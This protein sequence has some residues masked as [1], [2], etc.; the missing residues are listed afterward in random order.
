MVIEQESWQRTLALVRKTKG[1]L[2]S[3]KER[4][5]TILR[6]YFVKLFALSKTLSTLKFR[7]V[8]FVH[9]KQIGRL[10]SYRN[11]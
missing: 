10:V 5:T 9:P 4:P 1:T 8:A 7:G 6:F 2:R 3:L 11:P